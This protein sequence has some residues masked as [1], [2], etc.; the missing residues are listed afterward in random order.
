M[1]TKAMW[2]AGL[3]AAAAQNADA[4]PVLTRFDEWTVIADVAPGSPEKPQL[5]I[6]TSPPADDGT[7]LRVVIRGPT[8]PP[9]TITEHLLLSNPNWAIGTESHGPIT[10]ERGSDRVSVEMSRRTTDT[11]GATL[12]HNDPESRKLTGIL[13]PGR[14]ATPGSVLVALPGAQ[15]FQVP[16]IPWAARMAIDECAHT[17]ETGLRGG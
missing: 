17:I 3:L 6:L 1:R 10:L 9:R 14:G 11:V 16:T 2:L 12:E 4:A 5:C 13:I 15:S 8:A 7:Y